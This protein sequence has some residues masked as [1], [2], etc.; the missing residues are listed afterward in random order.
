MTLP[1]ALLLRPMPRILLPLLL[2]L[3]ASCGGGGEPAGPIAPAP[4]T[5]AR[6]E[7]SP[8]AALLSTA[9]QSAQF[10]ATAYDDQGQVVP[11]SIT[12]RSSTAT[13]VG[14]D[15]NGRI[16]ALAASGSTQIVAEAG[17][18]AAAPAFVVV[19]QPTAGT[20]LVDDAQ[21]IGAPQPLGTGHPSAPGF[22]YQ[23]VLAGLPALASGQLLLGRGEI[24]IG[25]RVVAVESAV[26]AGAD[27]RVTLET[28]RPAEL[29]TG[30]NVKQTISLAQAPVTLS[31]AV[32]ANYDVERLADGSRRFT[33][34]P[35]ARTSS[36]LPGRKRA[37]AAVGTT[38]F[39]FDCSTDLP[40]PST[41]FP[42]DL[43]GGPI[44]SITPDF[45]LDID[46][47]PVIGL[48][49]LAV[50]GKPKLEAKLKPV[51]KTALSA[52]VACELELFTIDLPPLGVLGLL[53]GG[54]IPVDVGF[55]VEGKLDLTFAGLG[56]EANATGAAEFSV[57]IHNCPTACEPLTL[58]EDK[59]SA[60]FKLDWPAAAVDPSAEFGV[61]VFAK[62]DLVVGNPWLASYLAYASAKTFEAKLGLKQDLKL[63]S[64]LSQVSSTSNDPGFKLEAKATM[65]LGSAISVLASTF[66]LPLASASVSFTLPLASA[67][68]GSF[69]ITPSSVLPGDAITPG[70]KATFTVLLDKSTYLGIE[71]VQGL[72]FL[73][74]KP[75][76]S[77]VPAPADCAALPASTGQIAFSCETAF[78]YADLGTQTFY[79]FMRA[80]L[81][82]VPLPALFEIAPD[83]K[84]MV[85]V[86][87]GGGKV[88][89]LS[90]SGHAGVHLDD[91]VETSP[92]VFD[93]TT[94]PVIT[95]A[96]IGLSEAGTTPI[97][98][99]GARAVTGLATHKVVLE[100]FPFGSAD[101][102]L[103]YSAKLELDLENKLT[104]PG[105]GDT[106]VV[107]GVAIGSVGFAFSVVDAPVAY[108]VTASVATAEVSGA[109]A[110]ASLVAEQGPHNP[111]HV[112]IYKCQLVQGPTTTLGSLAPDCEP[113][114]FADDGVSA[115]GGMLS[116]GRYY[117][118]I[119]ARVDLAPLFSE[120]VQ[121]AGFTTAAHRGKVDAR[122]D[123]V[124]SVP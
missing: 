47:D 46:H 98:S 1:T 31:D 122:I 7:I 40:T 53:V 81:F 56:L 82:G 75:G 65:G 103:G 93:I 4:A 30:L 45:S 8:K 54:W 115:P 73:W 102:V 62:A 13:E 109:R 39:G 69:T 57:G 16:T 79:A 51:L 17:S 85:G 59:S 104:V 32:L 95:L 18:V 108:A 124:F 34:K 97:R 67:P 36:A 43:A 72:E 60:A 26:G 112:R 5:V 10:T 25:G 61:E 120:T 90:H 88:R 94:D 64:A 100:S 14:V 41:A 50:I 110:Y 77:L 121:A 58:F 44:I 86:A 12:W 114:L 27:Q 106:A 42:I 20:L 52:K 28:V 113:H 19:A 96:P 105:A 123:L 29:L 48:K 6:I 15:G 92:V 11:A 2:L 87:P 68:T 66:S 91:L 70:Q 117:V 24:P 33:A 71:S 119:R 80:R 22:R 37:A 55:E 101:N 116:L 89:A 63:A 35:T 23:V 78:T 107:Q 3:L 118:E 84:A 9:G 74:L 111:F 49:K 99:A 21:V 38:A 83:A 76:G